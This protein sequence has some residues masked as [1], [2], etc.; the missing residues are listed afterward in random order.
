[1]SRGPV[2]ARVVVSSWFI[3]TAATAHAQSAADLAT[4]E[5]LFDDGKQLMER[6]AYAEACPKL[7]ASLRIDVGIG[8]M[9][10]LAE[11][12]AHLG[13]TASAWGQFRE[14]AA[15]AS[16]RRDAREALA[17]QRAAQ[18]EPHLSRLIV[19]LSDAS[20]RELLVRRD[21][22]SLDR[23]AWG[24]PVP[25]DPGVH[26]IEVSAPG[27]KTFSATVHVD[28]EAST[29]TVAVPPLQ[30][31]TPPAA[32]A[33]G[34]PLAPAPSTGGDPAPGVASSPP[35]SAPLG[36]RRVMALAAGGL[37]VVGLGLGTYW[38]FDAKSHLDDSNAAGH[39]HGNQ[40]D[41][42]GADARTSAQN[43]ADLATVA[44]V[45]S[46]LAIGTG[47]VLWLT[48]PRARASVTLVPALAPR[49]RGLV[50]TGAF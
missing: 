50:L 1:V 8:A 6:G 33:L 42:Y 18:L 7:A 21:G 16:S 19:T 15:L 22:E 2:L 39:C 27:R 31:L 17:R 11:C 47:A 30:E 41:P 28:R 46:G 10:Y 45:V 13:Q 3:L 29:W 25:V 36:P 12:Y 44:F 38:A 34:A 40:C 37:G 43:Q 14:A 26:V 23:A 4:A 9:L 48:A 35:R 49:E 5:A 20:A 24:T 32:P